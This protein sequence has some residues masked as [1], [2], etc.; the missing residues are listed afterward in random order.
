MEMKGQDGLLRI[1]WHDSAWIPVL[2]GTNV[3]DYF[4]ERSNPFY[5]RTCNNEI[6]KMQRLNVDQLTNMTGLE[7][8]LLHVQ[9][10]ILYVIRKQHRHSAGETTP[11]ADYYIIAGVVYQAPDLGSVVN[12]RLLNTVHHLQQAFDECLS[13]SRYNPSKGYSWEFKDKQDPMDEKMNAKKKEKK[14]EPSSLFQRQ[15]VDMLLLE[16]SKKF[17]PK[18]FQIEGVP[19]PQS[20]ATAAQLPSGSTENAATAATTTTDANPK[21]ITNSSES[22]PNSNQNVD[23]NQDVKPDISLIKVKVEKGDGAENSAP[24]MKPPPEKRQKL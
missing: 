14:E 16:L 11:I 1:S 15:R 5:D 12:S 18:Q 10:P 2:N 24:Q 23:T 13:Y 4:S 6:V 17:P 19:P 8:I 20:K 21:Q 7:Y 22:A 9:E 3:L